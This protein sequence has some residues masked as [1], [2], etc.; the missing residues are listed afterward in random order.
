MLGISD[1]STTRLD[2]AHAR[3]WAEEAN[4]TAVIMLSEKLGDLNIAQLLR[5]MADRAGIHALGRVPVY[6]MAPRDLTTRIFAERGSAFRGRLAAMTHV[7]ADV[8]LLLEAEDKLMYPFKTEMDLLRLRPKLEPLLPPTCSFLE[9][10][11]V[12]RTLFV[13]NRARLSTAI[14]LLDPTESSLL[15][16]IPTNLHNRKLWNLEVEELVDIAAAFSRWPLKNEFHSD[17][18]SRF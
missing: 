15:D 2:P 16:L 10:E 4:A 6:M 5:W 14:K 13:K 12:V 18:L 8:D 17:S 7:M 9:Y 11:Y 3:P 1:T